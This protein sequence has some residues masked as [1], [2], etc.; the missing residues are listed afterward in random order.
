MITSETTSEMF[1][2]LSK[3]SK[4]I[5]EVIK[6]FEALYNTKDDRN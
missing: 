3:I 2:E 5:Q 1:F 6:G 4:A